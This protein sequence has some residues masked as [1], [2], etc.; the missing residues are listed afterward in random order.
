MGIGS[1]RPEDVT[2]TRKAN[3]D[4]EFSLIE[5]NVGDALEK[6]YSHFLGYEPKGAFSIKKGGFLR[7]YWSFD[8]TKP[9]MI[10]IH[11][12]TDVSM[13]IYVF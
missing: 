4:F 5:V 2:P 12:D 11:R 6:D 13:S 3:R 9:E 10:R 7:W 1:F 8:S